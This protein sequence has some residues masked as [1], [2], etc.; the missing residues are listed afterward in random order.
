[1]N[2]INELNQE[3]L[4]L[5]EE[6]EKQTNGLNQ[7]QFIE[8][9][10]QSS[11]EIPL[12]TTTSNDENEEIPSII[13]NNLA[14]EQVLIEILRNELEDYIP[15]NYNVSINEIVQQIVEEI[16]KEREQS[17]ERYQALEKAN[18][19]L[20]L[21]LENNMESIRQSYTNTVNELN[22]ELL[23]MKEQCEQLD[24]IDKELIIE[25]ENLNNQ[26]NDRSIVVGHHSAAES[27]F[28]EQE[29]LI[30]NNQ[31][32]QLQSISI[33][34][35]N[36]C[37]T[38]DKYTQY[39]HKEPKHI[40]TET[41]PLTYK[42]HHTQMDPVDITHQQC[43]TDISHQFLP[44]S[45]D[46]DSLNTNEINNQLN[47]YINEISFQSSMDLSNNLIKE[48][49]QILSKQNLKLTSIPNLEL[50]HLSLITIYFLYQQYLSDNAKELYNETVLRALQQEC[51]LLTN[52]K[53]DLIER[54]NSMQEKFQKIEYER[55]YS[56]EI[57][58]NLN[59]K[60]NDK[61]Y[62]QL[63]KEYNQLL[64]ENQLLKDYNA[65]IYQD[66]LQHEIE[67][68]SVEIK[69]SNN[70]DIQCDLIDE[71]QLSTTKE[72][73]LNKNLIEETTKQQIPIEEQLS[74][75]QEI[76]RLKTI[77]EEIKIENKN[78]K[79]LNS[80]LY[81]SINN[82]SH[83]I[84]IQS[85]L[86]LTSIDNQQHDDI[87]TSSKQ[88]IDNETQ[89]DDQQHDKLIQVNNKLKRALQT[90]KEKIHRVVVERP[91]L[92][93]DS[94]D[95]TI[96][97]LDH[98][99]SAVGHQAAQ[100]ELLK[101]E[102]VVPSSILSEQ[103]I[104]QL[105]EERSQ[106][107]EDKLYN[108]QEIHSLKCQLAKYEQELQE[109]N[110]KYSKTSSN[111]EKQV[112]A[113]SRVEQLIDNETQTDDQQHDKLVQVNNKLKRALQTIKEKIHHIVVEQPELFQNSTDDTLERLD[114]LISAVGQQ[115]VQIKNLQIEHDHKQ[116][117]INELQSSFE[118]YRYEIQNNL[119]KEDQDKS[120]LQER[121]NEI[122]LQLKKTLDDHSS[123]IA[124][125]E[126][127]IQ[128]RDVLLEQQNL[129]SIEHQ[130]E[131]E[132]LRNEL[133]ELKQTLNEEIKSL[134]ETIQQQSEKLTQFNETNLMLSS[135]LDTQKK[136]ME[137]QTNELDS[138]TNRYTKLL[139]SV[140]IEKT[141]NESQTDDRQHEKLIQV[142]NKL[143][144]ILQTFKEKIHRI[145]IEKPNLF[146]G[147][148]EETS[149]RLDH[150]ISI[151][152][153]QTTQI[154]FI[155]TEHD[156]L[157]KQLRNEIKELQ[158]SLETSQNELN[159]ERQVRFEQLAS[160]APSEDISSSIVEDYQKQIDE[161]QQKLSENN[162][163]R[164][165]L[166]DRLS[167]VELEL[168]ETKHTHELTSTKYRE[169]LLSLVE[170][171]NELLEQEAMSSTEH[172]RELEQLKKK[173][174][175]IQTITSGY[176]H[177]EIQTIEDI[178]SL[179]EILKQQTEELN[180]LN[181]KNLH[182]IS[183]DEFDKHKK[184]IEERLIERENQIDNLMQQRRKLL[185]EIEKNP[186]III[187]KIDN[188][189]QTD[190]YK[191]EKLVQVNNKL[192]RAL[193]T[194][195]DKI[196]RIVNENP[197]LFNGISEETNERLDHL[198]SIV[199]NQ[200]KQIHIIE[201]E[202]QQ[203]NQQYQQQIKELQSSL[204]TIESELDNER[205]QHILATSSS[206]PVT[207]DISSSIIEDYQT[208]INQLE[209]TLIEKE[210]EQILLRERLNEI[211][212]ELRKIL[213]DQNSTLTKYETLVRERNVLVEQ[214]NLQSIEHQREVEQLRDELTEYKQT[215]RTSNE[216]IKSLKETI[217]QQSEKLA[218]LNETN[219]M[220]S[221]QFDTQKKEM[222]LQT[223]ELELITEEHTKLLEL[224]LIEKTDNESQTDDHQ[225][226][227]LIQVNN[228]LK[229][230]LQTFKEK[231]H[232]IVI[233]KPNLFDGISEE[234]SE[235]LDH[236]ILIV[237]NQ[238]IQI[239][240]IQTERDQLE[241]Q[242]RNEIKELQRSLE[243]IQNELNYERQVRIEQL[244]S[245]AP[246]EDISSSI[247]EDYQ[248]QIDELQQKIYENNEERSLLCDR[249]SKVE[250]E[251][252]ET[253]HTH[254][255]TSMKYKEELLSLVEE[256]NEL[257]KQEAMSSTEHQREIEQLKKNNDQIR[258]E[259]TKPKQQ[260][261]VCQHVEVQTYEDIN[262]LHELL[263]QQIEQIKI[264]KERC[265][266]LANQ[267]D[268]HTE[269]QTEIEREKKQTD[270]QIN[271]YKNQIEILMRERTNLLQELEK[272]TLSSIQTI[273]NECQTNDDDQYKKTKRSLKT[274]KYKIYRI[275][276]ERPDLFDGIGQET[277]ER[278]DH[279]ISIVQNQTIKINTLQTER[280]LIEE[281][282][283]NEIKELQNQ[284]EI[285]LKQSIDSQ[286]VETQTD[287]DIQ[288]L[289]K[290]L[291]DLNEKNLILLSQI[292][293]QDELKKQKKE[294][295]E[296]L[297]EYK[298]QIEN[299]M[300]ERQKLLEEIDDDD[301]HKKLIETN[302][303]LKCT[304]ETINNKINDIITTRPDLFKDISEETNVRLD[305][306][307]SIIEN[308]TKQIIKLQSE[309]DQATEKYQSEINDL[310]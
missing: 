12:D 226:E 66:K 39:E 297:N 199:E 293:S 167:E 145:V 54:I 309:Y 95:D 19:Q 306:L 214:Q 89:T 213:D 42:H 298:N 57:I 146:D 286:N 149:E 28:L 77:I 120:L 74:N 160:A 50:N 224:V 40:A 8:A 128:K 233:E 236:L 5:K 96:E 71:L 134:K 169:E 225:H 237:E 184:E 294:I 87:Q 193:Q 67:H 227:K 99:I 11:D 289:D 304:I 240:L 133:T 34:N 290:Q 238:T 44:V 32:S 170:E 9:S 197:D 269:L 109:S 202:H 243:T 253:K 30:Q 92:F 172:E 189:T 33:P 232:R 280:T 162:E 29:N 49:Q 300:N 283:R 147:I 168:K 46:E 231:I 117:E 100:I 275:V 266:S 48:C 148:S 119:S 205:Q 13:E 212:L 60:L 115:T 108:N 292:E 259:F 217:Q 219:L 180:I 190:D 2:T 154:D 235:R 65:Q 152:E 15:I 176:H 76:I 241:K 284:H 35:A 51:N 239:D 171:R 98:L 204:L 255:L 122:E 157:E 1:T 267:I 185:E 183:Q 305:S 73:I 201:T 295:E 106:L 165:L 156:Q 103:E 271:E 301:E 260:L 124:K 20:Q 245:A 21:E 72:S 69:S 263:G 52:E 41:I 302:N 206:L 174:D 127:L 288:T 262:A 194:I 177:V 75:Q 216:E 308:Q 79:D 220:L 88:M 59:D 207:E 279:L 175:Q 307:I 82:Q 140:A 179:Y 23:A 182:L 6:L 153:N 296:Q 188:E 282:L 242:L 68:G 257:L 130:R 38:I 129:Q 142:N 164:T 163:E 22:Q 265:L 143:K 86:R 150:L 62:E 102:P 200:T 138:L 14:W 84:D 178:E 26:M 37:E 281:Q 101:T 16:K 192:K 97:R 234:T 27:S 93:V 254:E 261:P 215:F 173:N 47:E 36:L 264:L 141:D 81:N 121:L 3:L 210:D 244:T 131:V 250:L 114:H 58:K 63:E 104:E 209:Q 278:L 287:E 211:E 43:Q 111:V 18:N 221:F 203:A 64:N 249:L 228:K 83:G 166:R 132:Q 135:Q 136:E 91:E 139:E 113:S 61:N 291:N 277:N 24:Q 105:I 151:V 195:K 112:Q 126:S 7:Q 186:S 85:S 247:V 252:K 196:H 273:N 230:I 10:K 53:N 310:Q 137:L 118:S 198:I 251:L 25:N 285:E 299:L 4:I 272:Y 303:T 116:N 246:S 268:S 161:L 125:F 276:N 78:L 270:E 274:L 191:H 56:E 208:K 31:Q 70:V 258:E 256:R 218:E 110:K 158:R 248:T 107:E 45:N 223:N 155:Q 181:E 94:T 90:I 159:Y 55:L 80:Q 144:R 222:E 229:R 17:N 123:T 187:Q